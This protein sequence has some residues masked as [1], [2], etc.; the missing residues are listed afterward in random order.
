VVPPLV[1]D[2]LTTIAIEEIKM[3]P[4]PE[5]TDA[6][7]NLPADNDAIQQLDATYALT[8]STIRH[9]FDAESD[10]TIDEMAA[11]EAIENI[12]SEQLQLQAQILSIELAEIDED[13]DRVMEIGYPAQTFSEGLVA[14]MGAEFASFEEALE[15]V[16]ANTGI[17][18]DTLIDYCNGDDIPSQEEA[19]AI[20]SCFNCMQ[21]DPDAVDHLVSLADDG[22]E[23]MMADMSR[24]RSQFDAEF[25][26]L[27]RERAEFSRTQELQHR[28]KAAERLAD[29]ML[30]SNYLSP[31]ERRELLPMNIAAD[32]RSDFTAFFSATAQAMGVSPSSYMDCVEFTMQF[33]SK[34]GKIQPT[35]ITDFSAY[36]EPEPANREEMEYLAAYRAKHSYC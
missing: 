23:D 1:L 3:L 14:L 34:R 22:T 16:S 32:D 24:Q 27:K 31:A 11:N 7:L 12:L 5:Q 36:Q 20:A 13:L 17:D 18:T 26:A 8:R 30:A 4:T 19:M 10:G 25:A 6:E 28:I 33:L 21:V 9:I 15:M 2:T 35:L 29:E